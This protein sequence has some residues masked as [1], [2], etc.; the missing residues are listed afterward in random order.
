AAGW[1]AVK[2]L[3]HMASNRADNVENIKCVLMLA[4]NII[5]DY[6]VD[7]DVFVSHRRGWAFALDAFSLDG[8][9]SIMPRYIAASRALFTQVSRGVH[10]T[11]FM[12]ATELFHAIASEVA[13]FCVSAYSEVRKYAH[14]VQDDIV[15]I[16]PAVKYPLIPMFLA[17]LYEREESDPEKMNGALRVLDTPAFRRP[18]LRDWTH[19]PTLVLALCRAQ[20]E[21]KPEVKRLVRSTA[22]GQVVL[23]SAPLPPLQ[24]LPAARELV[25]TLGGGSGVR[26]AS[27]DA[28]VARGHARATE[29]YQFATAENARLINA[30]V[31]IQRDAGT[32]WRFAAVSGYYLDQLVSV[33][34]PLEPRLMRTLAENLTSDLVLFRENAAVNLAQ[35]LGKI[36]RRSKASQ[37]QI[38]VCERRV[39][40]AMDRAAARGI[41]R[42]GY[43]DLCERAL[44][45]D[46]AA[47]AAPYVDSPACGWFVWPRATKAYV[48]PP[49][50]DASAYDFIEPASQPAYEEVR[51]VLFASG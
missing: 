41:S 39:E 43:A 40:L 4:Q 15:S 21:D 12:P 28:A 25:E 26:D 14:V 7:R 18:C 13:R 23:V 50:G 27:F 20:H 19:F 37:P 11:R 16:L 38:A 30:L 49:P 36:K 46:A 2:T 22:V 32:T 1:A 48:Q 45:G 51:S 6:G 47:A 34:M 44:A 29:A 42:A 24:L 35:L 10:N 5:C 9:D 17:E 8:R 31:D 33:R 3:A